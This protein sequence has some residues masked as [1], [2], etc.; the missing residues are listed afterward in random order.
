MTAQKIAKWV[1]VVIGAVAVFYLFDRIAGYLEAAYNA[2]L[3]TGSG[4]DF[5]TAATASLNQS[6]QIRSIC[7]Q[8][9]TP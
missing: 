1:M 7:Q 8:P 9:K 4:Y 6:W 2:A 5:A 3:A